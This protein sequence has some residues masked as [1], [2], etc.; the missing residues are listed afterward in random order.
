MVIGWVRSEGDGAAEIDAASPWKRVEAAQRRSRLPCLLV[1]QPAHAV[2]AGRFAEALLPEPFGTLP[3]E[4]VQAI[5][6][7]DTGWAMIDAAQIQRLRSGPPSARPVSFIEN[8]PAESIEAW[9]ASI[10][11]AERLGPGAGLVVSRHFTLLGRGP[12]HREFVTAELKRQRRLAAAC[13]EPDGVVARWVDALGFCDLLSLYLICGFSQGAEFTLAH[14]DSPE[15]QGASRVRLIKEDN[16]L[17]FTPRMFKAG[18]QVE[19][20]ALRHPIAHPGDPRA[21]RLSWRIG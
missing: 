10:L 8:S 11:N 14:R 13:A 20:E 21:E 6:M 3:R 5:L 15:A 7:H 4:I 12:E 16:L 19:L 18:M 9:T 2:L 17:R 1:P